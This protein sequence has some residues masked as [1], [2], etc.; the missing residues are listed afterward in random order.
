MKPS[1]S[2]PLEFQNDELGT[3]HFICK[4][5]SARFSCL[6]VTRFKL[7]T[8]QWSVKGLYPSSW[9]HIKHNI[10]KMFRQL[11]LS[12]SSKLLHLRTST[13]SVSS[14]PLPQISRTEILSE[15]RSFWWGRWVAVVV[16][17][18]VFELLESR[19]SSEELVYTTGVSSKSLILLG[20]VSFSK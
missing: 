15:Y 2:D 14:F 12:S 5:R 11:L 6:D 20:R 10:H 3:F 19:N 4:S 18:C 8:R 13:F 7:V 9:Q 17:V 1:S 16:T